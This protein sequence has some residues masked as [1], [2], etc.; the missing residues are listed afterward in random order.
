V[1]GTVLF[2]I[3]S[4]GTVYLLVGSWDDLALKAIACVVWGIGLA[5]MV[6]LW[7]SQ[8]GAFFT[9]WRKSAPPRV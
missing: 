3:N 6:L 9:A 8:A 1:A 7:S 4:I 2:G 5:T